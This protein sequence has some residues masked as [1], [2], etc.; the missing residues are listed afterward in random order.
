MVSISLATRTLLRL[1]MT[2]AVEAALSGR[3]ATAGRERVGIL[4]AG[5]IRRWLF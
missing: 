4:G 3:L 1:G 2:V 5:H